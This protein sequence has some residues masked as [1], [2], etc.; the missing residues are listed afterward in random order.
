MLSFQNSF[1][2]PNKVIPSTE[3]IPAKQWT[4]MYTVKK[5]SWAFLHFN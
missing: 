2:H 3:T 1:E 4:G 5:H